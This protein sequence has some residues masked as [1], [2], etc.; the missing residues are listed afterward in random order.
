MKKGMLLFA[1]LAFISCKKQD[2]GIPFYTMEARKEKNISS[3]DILP[4]PPPF[5][6]ENYYS[7]HNIVIDSLGDLYYFKHKKIAWVC[8]TGYDSDTTYPAMFISL[9]PKDLTLIPKNEI[10]NFLRLNITDSLK[11]D[12]KMYIMV[13]SARDSFYSPELSKI[14]LTIDKYKD[15]RIIIRKTTQEEEIVL[16]Y[17]KKKLPYNPNLINWDSTRTI[18]PIAF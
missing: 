13:G 15:G 11:P 10:D 17:K 7:K 6:L 16:D 4:P 8:G 12:D 14:A 3:N 1:I 9:S 18:R 2:K 5:F